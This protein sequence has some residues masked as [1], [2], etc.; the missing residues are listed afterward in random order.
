MKRDIDTQSAEPQIQ[1]KYD[2]NSFSLSRRKPNIEKILEK[3]D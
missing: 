3:T 2:V 1:W